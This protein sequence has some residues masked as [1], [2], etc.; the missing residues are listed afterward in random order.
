MSSFKSFTF[1]CSKC[2]EDMN[3]SCQ[4]DIELICSKCHITYPKYRVGNVEI[5]DFI[6]LSFTGKCKCN[7]D[8]L[9]EC[10]IDLKAEISHLSSSR[11]TTLP[12]NP[13][14][15]KEFT[16]LRG[17]G[18]KILDLGCAEAPYA[19]YLSEGN[20]VCGLDSCARR[21]LLGEEN[22]LDKGYKVL[23]LADALEIPF[24]SEEFDAIL[25]T[26]LIKHVLEVKA[27]FQEINRI[28]IVGGYLILTT[29]NLV[30]LWNRISILFGSGKGLAPWRIVKGKGVHDPWSSIV[31]P[32][33][34]LHV[35]FFTFS[36]LKNLLKQFRFE[37][38]EAIGIDPIFSRLPPLDRLLK[39]LCAT[40]M[41]KAT[42]RSNQT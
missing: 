15:A 40:V 39:T 30:S 5:I 14:L 28:L 24:A 4:S 9:T 34:P 33:Q 7:R 22:A 6:D 41:V 31:Y 29:P 19:A 38:Q 36:S 20:S 17:K 2:G 16:S 21:L 25:C 1:R 23:V 35:R 18:M 11:R 37:P 13:R 32:D 12:S 3:P 26:E 27:F 42:K 8:G 10:A